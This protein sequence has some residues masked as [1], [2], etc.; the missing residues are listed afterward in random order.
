MK[1]LMTL[2]AAAA[3]A[4]V[5]MS[6]IAGAQAEKNPVIEPGQAIKETQVIHLSAAG[7]IY[8]AEAVIKPGT[9]VIWRN[10]SRAQLEL[11]FS[12]KQV[13]MACKS[14]VHFVV[15]DEGS[16]VSDRIPEDSV[17]S[18]CFIEK[19]EFPYVLRNVGGK[20]YYEEHR[21][22]PQEFKGKIIVK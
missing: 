14:P 15:D 1:K 11:Q 9:T 13:T 5:L 18:L 16:F 6:E 4:L 20:S 22:K 7:G 17:A 2:T 3:F 10:D 8:P 21:T 19:G 12:G